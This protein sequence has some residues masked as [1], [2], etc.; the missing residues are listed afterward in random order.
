MARED[1]AKMLATSVAAPTTAGVGLNR[2][3]ERRCYLTVHPRYSSGTA[4]ASM[5]A[6]VSPGKAP[7]MLKRRAAALQSDRLVFNV[8]MTAGHGGKSGLPAAP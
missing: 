3:R 4:S 5:R 1:R 6:H 2:Q 7:P 8:D